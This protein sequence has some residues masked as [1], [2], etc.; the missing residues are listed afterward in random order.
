MITR[1]I[2][3]LELANL[4]DDLALAADLSLGNELLAVPVPEE[5][6]PVGLTG[7]RNDK[8]VVFV[9]ECASDELT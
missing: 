5:D 9:I 7:E 4:I 8:A 3:D 1:V 6:L 2:T